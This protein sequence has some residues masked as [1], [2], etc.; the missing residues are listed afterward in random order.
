MSGRQG[1]G[2]KWTAPASGS[3]IN[4]D[5]ETVIV[6]KTDIPKPKKPVKSNTPTMPELSPREKRKNLQTLIQLFILKGRLSSAFRNEN[7]K[8]KT[9]FT[10]CMSLEEYD[11]QKDN[12]ARCAFIQEVNQLADEK[13][14]PQP[15]SR[16]ELNA[17]HMLLKDKATPFLKSL[18]RL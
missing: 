4:Q 2:G 18:S 12:D 9:H 15:F 14:V 8:V 6:R 16:S 13:G 10:Y 7:F 11:G 3:G 1:R 5:T 17:G